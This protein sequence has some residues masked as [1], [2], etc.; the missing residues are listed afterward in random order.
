MLGTGE[1]GNPARSL[2]TFTFISIDK[3]KDNQEERCGPNSNMDA[4]LVEYGCHTCKCPQ[5][6][7]L[8]REMSGLQGRGAQ[9]E[10]R[11]WGGNVPG[12]SDR[13]ARKQRE[14]GGAK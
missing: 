12:V 9:P 8:L 10:Q 2:T 6:Y 4:I 14:P 3:Q 11:P 7:F 5:V 1:T 13:K